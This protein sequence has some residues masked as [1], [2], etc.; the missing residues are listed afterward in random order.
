M[1]KD[2]PGIA[3]NSIPFNFRLSHKSR[4]LYV[5]LIFLLIATGFSLPLIRIPVIIHARGII[6]PETDII[7]ILAPI[8]GII[9]ECRMD[10][11]MYVEK[12]DTLIVFDISIIGEETNLLLEKQQEYKDFMDDLGFIAKNIYKILKS[13]RYRAEYEAFKHMLSE[14]ET[15]Q[16]QMEINLERLTRLWQ[17][18]LIS[19]KELEDMEFQVKFIIDEKRTSISSQQ[20]RWLNEAERYKSELNNLNVRLLQLKEA[21]AKSVIKAP[22]NGVIHGMKGIVRNNYISQYQQIANISPDTSF[23]AEVYIPPS[24]IGWIHTGIKG[25]MLID[26]YN[27]N[28]WG[29]MDTECISVSDD[30]HWVNNQP[31]F[32]ARCSIDRN[33][34]IVRHGYSASLKKGMTLTIQFIVAERSLFELLTDNVHN[35]LAVQKGVK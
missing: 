1:I 13:D 30:Y 2:K 6:R 20:A 5:S 17:D 35:W 4:A 31:F 10:E 27:S 21:S 7:K 9:A 23:Y 3:E 15:K 34:L 11:G 29:A 32:L 24:D 26:A 28:Y 14:K 12:D 33:K 18:S 19:K 8:S 25:K 22:V 16:N